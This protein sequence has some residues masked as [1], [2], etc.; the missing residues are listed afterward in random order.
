M[1]SITDRSIESFKDEFQNPVKSCA[2]FYGYYYLSEIESKN[3]LDFDLQQKT[4][5]LYEAF[6]AYGVYAILNEL[7]NLRGQA[8]IHR[9]A[10]KQAAQ[11]LGIAIGDKG[12]ADR[13]SIAVAARMARSP[14]LRDRVIGKVIDKKLRNDHPIDGESLIAA[15]GKINPILSDE[16]NVASPNLDAIDSILQIGE[17]EMGAKSD[18]EATIKFAKDIFDSLYWQPPF[19]G[20]SWTDICKLLQAREDN[21]KKI[22]VDM[23]W[24]TEHNTSSWVNKVPYDSKIDSY[25]EDS[26]QLL[27]RRLEPEISR[28]MAGSYN[29]T[30]VLELI[31]DYKREGDFY[32]FWPFITSAGPKLRRYKSTLQRAGK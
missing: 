10:V 20:P 28:G 25:I 29:V 15:V 23:A 32:K 3:E 13:V 7:T 26:I 24:A 8:V 4:D 31:L 16:I 12:Q 27:D 17:E 30:D 6:Y 21:P 9:Q 14:P 19:G 11:E 18:P 1:T 5:T 2:E 22:W